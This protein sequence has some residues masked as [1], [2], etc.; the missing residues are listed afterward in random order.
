MKKFTFAVL[1]IVL[2]SSVCVADPEWVGVGVGSHDRKWNGGSGGFAVSGDFS[3]GAAA[4]LF[5]G[6]KI[7][8]GTTYFEL[9]AFTDTGMCNFDV[10]PGRLQLVVIGGAPLLNAVAAGPTQSAIGNGGAV[11]STFI[12]EA[13]TLDHTAASTF[14]VLSGPGTVNRIYALNESFTN[15]VGTYSFAINGGALM[16]DTVSIPNGSLAGFVTSATP[17]TNNVFTAP[18]FGFGN[19]LD[20]TNDG[21]ATVGGKVTIYVE[22]TP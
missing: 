21:G 19:R 22:V 2:Q 20:I 16:D 5:W 14:Y 15:G 6:A 10:G 18:A 13:F 9:C 7:P 17:T 11:A 8:G 3:G 4:T 1:L 12:A